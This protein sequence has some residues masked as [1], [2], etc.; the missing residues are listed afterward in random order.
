[1][2]YDKT[3]PLSI[4][5]YS[6]QLIGKSLRDVVAESLLHTRLGKGGLGQLVEEL[7]FEYSVN[8]DQR[9]DFEEANLELK[10]SPVK[11]L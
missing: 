1:M 2:K 5:D 9:A 8:N 3:S 10:C 11:E 4:F 6:K 7:F